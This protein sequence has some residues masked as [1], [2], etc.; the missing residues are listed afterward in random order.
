MLILYRTTPY[1]EEFHRV[2][3]R[4]HRV[5]MGSIG[6]FNG[7]SSDF[8]SVS[9]NRSTGSSTYSTGFHRAVKKTNAI[10]ISYF[11]KSFYPIVKTGCKASGIY[12]QISSKSFQLNGTSSNFLL[13]H[14]DPHPVRPPVSERLLCICK[15]V[16]SKKTFSTHVIKS[17]IKNDN[18][19]CQLMVCSGQPRG[20][21]FS[22][23]ARFNFVKPSKISISNPVIFLTI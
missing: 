13:F 6:Y 5:P 19:S 1:L 23:N 4:F 2:P 3:F 14:P 11:T 22:R 17:L 16:L 7:G 8:D 10:A 21:I 12:F 20:I 15:S 18:M 9:F